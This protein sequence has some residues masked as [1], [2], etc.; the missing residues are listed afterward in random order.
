MR[1]PEIRVGTPDRCLL[2]V[3]PATPQT[4]MSSVAISMKFAGMVSVTD[5]AFEDLG[6]SE[7]ARRFHEGADCST[8]S[9]CALL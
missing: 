8:E 6:S 3:D 2:V 1:F 4:C 9:N 5:A 7:E